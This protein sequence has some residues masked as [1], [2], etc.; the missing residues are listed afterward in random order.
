MDSFP[1]QRAF[2]CVR[3]TLFDTPDRSLSAHDVHK[4][5]GVDIATCATVLDDLIR[6][7]LLERD[8]T[9]AARRRTSAAATPAAAVTPASA[10]EPRASDVRLADPA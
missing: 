6:S 4:L 2:H 1:Y 7:R 3:Q 5:C 10:V 8:S 9:G